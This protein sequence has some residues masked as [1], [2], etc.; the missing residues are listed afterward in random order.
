MP[1]PKSL[2]ANAMPV[3]VRPEKLIETVSLKLNTADYNVRNLREAERPCINEHWS[4]ENYVKAFL[5]E[6]HGVF[7]VIKTF[8]E[9]SLKPAG[10]KRWLTGWEATLSAD[11]LALWKQMRHE[12]TQYEHGE[13]IE[14]ER[15]WIVVTEGEFPEAHQGTPAVVGGSR[16]EISKVSVRFAAFPD[17]LASDVCAEHL[18]LCQQ[19]AVEFMDGNAGLFVAPPHATGAST[20]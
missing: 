18:E 5:T 2:R 17:R 3:S 19:F 12:R 14:L 10:F 4:P 6:A 13:G 11:K 20:A 15:T 16:S 7:A 8:A 1:K 9:A